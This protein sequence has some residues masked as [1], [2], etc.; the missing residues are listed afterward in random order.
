MENRNGNF[1][2]PKTIFAVVLVGLMWFGWQYHLQQ[3][4]PE[5]YKK[6]ETAK[7]SQGIKKSLEPPQAA[8]GRQKEREPFQKETKEKKERIYEYSSENVDFEISSQGMALQNVYL[9]KYTDRENQTIVLNSKN[10]N[11]PFK[12]LQSNFVDSDEAI[13]FEISKKDENTYVGHY[14]TEFIKIE[15]TL[16]IDPVHY[17]IS[18][19]IEISKISKNFKGISVFL[20]EK[21]ES[22]ED[23]GSF[24][25]PQFGRQEAYVSYEDTDNRVP[26]AA[27]E[28]IDRDE[29]HYKQVNLIALSSH[30]FSTALIDKSAILPE[31][32]IE[33]NKAAQMIVARVDYKPTNHL[34]SLEIKSLFFI[35]PKS[36]NLM[37]EVD[38]VLAKVIDFGIFHS[39]AVPM[40]KLMN[41]FFSLFGNYGLAIILLTLAVRTVVLPFNLMSYKSMKT[42]QKVQPQIKALREKYKEEPQK[43]NQEMLVLMREN[44]ANP[45]GGCLPMLLQF[46]VFIALYQVFGQSIE[47]YKAPFALW[48]SDLSLKDPYFILPIAMGIT[49]FLQQKITPTSMDPA[50]AKILMFMPIMF[51]LFMLFLPSALTLYIFISTLYAILQQILFL[52]DKKKS[53]AVTT[54]NA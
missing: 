12:S 28:N 54:A 29:A 52:K 20:T 8:M 23:K 16:F 19:V 47:L 24:F 50:Q 13:P 5:A 4:Y 18:S 44:K 10:N 40:L 53:K 26:L 11:F 6:K 22:G 33:Q 41:W 7:R 43:L 1:M 39:L 31:V 38:G 21:M 48:I 25:M 27:S 35:G 36:A 32:K 2:D 42:M 15:K 51:T 30:Y 3:K 14:V 37:E 9:K 34:N 45:L 17:T 46:P 49:M